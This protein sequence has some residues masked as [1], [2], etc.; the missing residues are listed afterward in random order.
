MCPQQQEHFLDNILGAL[1]V[2]EEPLCEPERRTGMAMERLG[3]CILVVATDANDERGVAGVGKGWHHSVSP[4][5]TG[6]PD[7]K[8]CERSGATRPCCDIPVILHPIEAWCRTTHITNRPAPFGAGKETM[9]R[10]VRFSAAALAGTMAF[11]GM[12]GV[13]EAKKVTKKV[14]APTKDVVDTAV[15]AG[16]FKTLAVALKA[17]GLVDT[18]KGAGPFTVFA[19]TDA[20]FAKIPTSDLQALLAD[21][22]KLASILTY[23]VVVGRVPASE[24][25]K[26]GGQSV[27]TVNGASVTVGVSGSKVTLNGNVNVTATDVFATNGVIH[28]ID[29]VLLPP[30]APAPVSTT[31]LPAPVATPAPT[32]TAAAAIATGSTI[33]DL[34]IKD[35]RFKTLVAALGAAGLADTLKGP[36][37]FTVFAPTDTAFSVLPQATIANLL[38]PENKSA[39][40]SLLTYHVVSGKLLA[41]DVL[42]ATSLTT[43]NGKQ[44]GVRL[45]GGRPFVGHGQILITDIV[46]SNGVIHVIDTVLNPG[47]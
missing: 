29:T 30:A 6:S 41:A 35:G 20:A 47:Q 45:V 3:Q 18:L 25:V 26:L 16:S 7:D 10:L 39:L 33:V 28:V 21:K 46:A 5:P 31:T 14:A 2:A 27:K 37:P 40:T 22:A 11:V 12:T 19:P 4:L 38:K 34:A 9:Q 1:I 32:T 42:K 8:F 44:L 36:G 23:H 15:A 13:A 24:V 43:L 17:A